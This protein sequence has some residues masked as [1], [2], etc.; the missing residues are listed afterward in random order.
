MQTMESFDS[1]YYAQPSHRE[2]KL[3]FELAPFCCNFRHQLRLSSVVQ[4]PKR[5][6]LSH[7]LRASPYDFSSSSVGS[8]YLSP[9]LATLISALYA[10][11]LG[12]FLLLRLAHVNTRLTEPENCLWLFLPSAILI[13]RSLLLLGHWCLLQ[14]SIPKP[15]N[16]CGYPSVHELC[17]FANISGVRN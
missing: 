7:S 5:H 6:N 8:S 13:P 4:R 11:P 17:C 14:H 12:S 10:G 16:H 9:L 2:V 1:F 3:I 15:D